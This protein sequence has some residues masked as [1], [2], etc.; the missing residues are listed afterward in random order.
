MIVIKY[1]L[2][3]TQS[4][5][6]VIVGICKKR[7]HYLRIMTNP[8]LFGGEFDLLLDAAPPGL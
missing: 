5:S 6:V 2:K 8:A 4:F 3:V 1:N 7:I